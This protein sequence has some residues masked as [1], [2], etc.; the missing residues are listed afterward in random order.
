MEIQY[1]ENKKIYIRKKSVIIDRR[2]AKWLRTEYTRDYDGDYI[3]V[4]RRLIYNEYIE[5]C[6]KYDIRPVS[7]GTFGK[8]ITAIY[9]ELKCG[10]AWVLITN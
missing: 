7:D 3:G 5:I 2:I 4:P 9:G 1:T 8:Y 6:A 10:R